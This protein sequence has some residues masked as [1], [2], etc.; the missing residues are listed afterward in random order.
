MT[1]LDLLAE[2]A[3]EVKRHQL[4]FLV[5]GLLGA[6]DRVYPLGL[7]TKVLSTVF[8]IFTRPIVAHIAK[9]HGMMVEESPQTIYPDFT[10]MD[11]RDSRRKIAIDIKTTYRRP[12][13]QFTLG[14]YTSF[15]RNGTKNILFPYADYAQ[16][17]I[18][19][20]VYD[21]AK[22][23]IAQDKSFD[24]RNEISIP[25]AKV[26]WFVQEKY[27][28][29][30]DRPGSGNTANIGS[31]RSTALSDFV[32]GNGPFA[33]LGE[34]V[35]RDYWANFGKALAGRTYANVADYLAWKKKQSP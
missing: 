10:V 20:F 21:R 30:G 32:K 3:Q 7:D 5:R 24:E 19:G 14:S 31:I 29:S 2:F 11:S 1:E 23:P 26:E 27:K 22:I 35:F 15:L 34:K 6:N 4:D 16:H 18:I 9:S 17:W 25:Y 12:G 33:M 8:E 28:I 13:I